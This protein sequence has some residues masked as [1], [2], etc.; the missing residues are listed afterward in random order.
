VNK[1]NSN[2]KEQQIKER[3]NQRSYQEKINQKLNIYPNGWETVRLHKE[4][5]NIFLTLSC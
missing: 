5:L 1:S 4:I 3:S 2:Q